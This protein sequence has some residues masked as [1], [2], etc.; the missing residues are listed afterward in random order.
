MK[1]T[2]LFGVALVYTVC[3]QAQQLPNRYLEEVSSKL[4]ITQNVVFST[5]IPSVKTTNLFGNKLAN[6]DSY[7]QVN[8][9]LKMDIY[10][11]STDTLSKKP[12]IIFA[13]G[14]GFVNG[15]RT[16]KSMIQLCQAFAKRGFVTAT[17][18][19]RVGMNIGDKELSKRAVYRAVQD[20]RSAVRYFRKN[21]ALY[22]IDENQIY[23]SGHSSGAF[24]A[25]QNIYLDKDSERPASTRNY[26]GRLDLGGLDDIGDSKTYPN[27]TIINGKANGTM[28]FAGAL[29]DLAYIESVADVPGV[30][31]HSSD[32]KTVPYNSGEPFSAISWLPGFN[33]PTVYGSNQMGIKATSV[34]APHVFYPYTNRGHNVHFD[35]KNIF[36]DISPLGSQFFYDSKLKPS[37][38]VI[39]GNTNVCANCGSQN[40]SASS[41]AFYY[42]W[43]V[44]GG[45]FT[46]RNPLS[47][48]VSVQW[49][50]NAPMHILTATPYSR[51]LARG[52]AIALQ[53]SINQTPE[54]TKSLDEITDITS[55]NLN[56]YF[57]DPEGQ[58][59][60]Y[61][62]TSP[63]DVVK[64]NNEVNS[65]SNNWLSIERISNETV[66]ITIEAN[67]GNT[68]TTVRS[69]QL[70][71]I[72]L[73]EEPLKVLVSP[74]PFV[75]SA[76]ISLEGDYKGNV[77]IV[78]YDGNGN[79]LSERKGLKGDNLLQESFSSE[80][81]RQGIHY[82]KV[83]TSD[84]EIVKRIVK[85]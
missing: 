70:K 39:T 5:N 4:Q 54:L 47:N 49:N 12:V 57:S 9:T 45:S 76:T 64:V 72:D 51:Q 79:R 56:D 44:T 23:L 78:L 22:G 43:Q 16:E 33:L 58:P 69:F 65:V 40:Y 34:S 24:I 17:I 6:E 13:F 77:T 55:I 61:K 11:A 20:G 32:D 35:G 38:A 50:P 2:L 27:G 82:I 68:C 14:G 53:I 74:N 3:S 63:S 81:K 42:D 10:R 1:K 66:T 73:L 21:A 19:Y 62:V 37:A 36:T 52:N 59:L 7:G 28:G 71:A 41:S 60:F 46:S 25:L 48:T 83:I 8:T 30:Y 29:G 84:G 75:E 15:S 80:F 18:D 31:F 85:N 67:D 26:F